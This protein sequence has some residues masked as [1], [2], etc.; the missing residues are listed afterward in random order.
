MA[1]SE[2]RFNK[3]GKNMRFFDRKEEIASLQE[4]GRQAREN[5]QFTVVTGRT[6]HHALHRRVSGI[7]PCKQIGV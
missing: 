2:Y 1:V 4:I 6:P 3:I 7:F 5:A